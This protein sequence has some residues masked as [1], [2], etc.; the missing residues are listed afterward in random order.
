MED[1]QTDRQIVKRELYNQLIYLFMVSD[2]NVDNIY[3]MKDNMGNR[4][5][6]APKIAINFAR[7]VKFVKRRGVTRDIMLT[8][9]CKAH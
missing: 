6:L 7:I 2:E 9:M 4:I 3:N 5:D 1:G 8:K